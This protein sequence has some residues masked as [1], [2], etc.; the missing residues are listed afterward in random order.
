M[1]KFAEWLKEND[2]KQRGVAKKIG[3]STSSLHE[4]LRLG[5]IPTI[6]VAYAIEEYTKGQITVYDWIDQKERA[7]P[8]KKPK[9]TP[10]DTITE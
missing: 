5:K 8:K 9:K 6:K 2:K 10:K 4:I 1:N 7:I 3:I